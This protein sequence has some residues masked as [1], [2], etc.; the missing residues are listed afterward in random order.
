ML[1]I[2]R[3]W[4]SSHTHT[5]LHAVH[6]SPCRQ[7]NTYRFVNNN[8]NFGAKQKYLHILHYINV[9]VFP[10]SNIRYMPVGVCFQGALSII[11]A[12]EYAQLTLMCVCDL[13]VCQYKRERMSIEWQQHTSHIHLRIDLTEVIKFLNNCCAWHQRLPSHSIKS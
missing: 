7:I 5:P 6:T 11:L 8:E 3:F 1:V 4:L 10:L 9:A 2:V 13:H 12:A